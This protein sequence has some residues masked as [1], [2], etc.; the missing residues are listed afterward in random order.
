MTH[1]NNLNKTRMNKFWNDKYDQPEQIQDYKHEQDEQIQDDTFQQPEHIQD[2]RYEQLDQDSFDK[3]RR[4][5]YDKDADVFKESERSPVKETSAA[6]YDDD[7]DKQEIES[8][9]D[10]F[11]PISDIQEPE[12]QK[13]TSYQEFTPQETDDD[14]E[15]HD[16][17]LYHEDRH[18]E[19]HPYMEDDED[20]HIYKDVE[21]IHEVKQE[22]KPFFPHHQ[23]EIRKQSPSDEEYPDIDEVEGH[24]DKSQYTEVT[25]EVIEVIE[26]DDEVDDGV[27]ETTTTTVYTEEK[28]EGDLHTEIIREHTTTERTYTIT[29]ILDKDG[30][31]IAELKDEDILRI[32]KEK[33]YIDDISKETDDKQTDDLDDMD[34]M[35]VD[36]KEFREEK[37]RE[38]IK[39][40][41][42]E[43]S[44]QEETHELLQQEEPVKTTTQE[45]EF[46][47]FLQEEQA[48]DRSESK[49]EKMSDS[50]E[51]KQ[52]IDDEKSVHVSDFEPPDSKDTEQLVDTE[53]EKV[54]QRDRSPSE[55]DSD[56]GLGIE[57]GF[58]DRTEEFICITRTGDLF[59]KEHKKWRPFSS[60]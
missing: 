37:V 8:S 11:R 44:K 3:D 60:T 39:Q 54:T 15:Q 41:S 29:E 45:E 50:I 22:E 24:E 20:T 31:P 46:D 25:A 35:Q 6:F 10:D 33:Q 1:S 47:A 51:Y 32:T 4:E 19:Q 12:P 40:D 48:I 34:E 30:Q 13:P 7:E 26:G 38:I 59:E 5:S 18:Y 14:D 28:Q 49:V 56:A 43:I 57:E 9:K 16:Q 36:R 17:H 58:I 21:E 23:V 2:D 53:I 42:K 27:V 55:S 52:P